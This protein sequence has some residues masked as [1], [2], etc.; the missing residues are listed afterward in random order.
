MNR[1]IIKGR[2]TADPELK[3]TEANNAAYVHF[4]VAVDRK[5]KQEGQPT[6]DFFNLTA[7]NKT[8]EFIGNYFKKGQEILVEGRLQNRSWQTETGEN[9]YATDIIVESVEFCG[10]KKDNSEENTVESIPENSNIDSD[11]PF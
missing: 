6:A 11:L 3:Y 1:I 5:F 10:S 8:S 2:L 9:R 4:S 7:W